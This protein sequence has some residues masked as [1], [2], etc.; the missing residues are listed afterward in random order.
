MIII[1]SGP[2]GVGKGT[3]CSALMKEFD[4]KYSISVTTRLPRK[5]ETDGIQYWFC[6]DEE[7]DALIKDKRLLEYTEIFGHR[8]G[9][10]SNT[11]YTD[12][13]VLCEVNVSGMRAI[14]DKYLNVISFFIFPPSIDALKKRMRQRDSESMEELRQ[15]LNSAK[16]EMDM[17]DQYDY[18]IVNDNFL[19]TIN[20]IISIIKGKLQCG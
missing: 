3:I 7:F 14:K 13:H 15:R 11:F 18:I 2:S 8:Y 17:S 9:T 16:H 4:L 5:R 19:L 20:K 1:I 12:K 10:L 6:D